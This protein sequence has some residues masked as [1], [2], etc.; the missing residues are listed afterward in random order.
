M[1]S[2]SISGA[3]G[4]GPSVPNRPSDVMAVKALL[5]SYSD[6]KLMRCDPS[7]HLPADSFVTPLFISRIEEFQR[8]VVGLRHPRVSS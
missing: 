2:K 8:K 3:V 1:Q 7:Q 6:Q 4:K 5:N